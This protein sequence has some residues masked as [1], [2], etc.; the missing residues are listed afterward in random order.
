MPINIAF[1]AFDVCMLVSAI[2]LLACRMAVLPRSVDGTLDTGVMCLLGW[3]IFLLTLSSAGILISRVLELDGGSWAEFL[4]ALSPALKVTHYGHVWVFRIPALILLWLAW[5]WC[6]RHRGHTWV[7]WLMAIALAGI[8][9]TRS[10]TGHP[11]DHGDFTAAVWVDWVHLM[12]ASVWVGSLFGMSLAVFP[13]LLHA[14]EAAAE[15]SAGIF[16]RLSILAGIALALV[17]AAGIYTAIGEFRGWSGLWTSAYGLTL[18]VKI[19]IVILMIGF[20]AHNRYIKLPRLMRAAGQPPPA[21]LFRAPYRRFTFAGA[22]RASG[23]AHAAVRS[24]ARA[25]LAESILGLAVIAAASVLL[26][27]MPPADMPQNIPGMYMQTSGYSTSSAAHLP[28]AKIKHLT[29]GASYARERNQRYRMTRRGIAAGKSSML[30]RRLDDDFAHHPGREMTG[31]MTGVFRQAVARE[32]P[33][34][35]LGVAGQ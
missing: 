9:L 29:V 10:E 3:A 20:G 28:T 15:Q 22:A 31:L 8:A 35:I 32:G 14:G 16:R 7:A 18:D 21:S 11:A 12:A 25:V 34:Q 19:F 33:H 4:T 30:R 2:G 13:K 1:T 6:L 26:H 5:G 17:L 24:C 23:D 27:S